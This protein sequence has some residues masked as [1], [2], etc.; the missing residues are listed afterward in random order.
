MVGYLYIFCLQ[1]VS[2]LIYFLYKVACWKIRCYDIDILSMFDREYCF[3][4]GIADGLFLFW[5]N[6]YRYHY[7][8]F[9]FGI[10][11][12]YSGYSLLYFCNWALRSQ[13][14]HCFLNFIPIATF[15]FSFVLR[16]SD[17]TDS[18]DRSIC[19]SAGL[20]LMKEDQSIDEQVNKKTLFSKT[21]IKLCK[22]ISVKSVNKYKE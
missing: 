6:T 18:D 20:M 2:L 22:N 11:L 16:R 13:V 5:Q 1:W 3:C 8:T 19:C 4:S 21:V 14:R 10:R 7:F 12:F 9:C 17:E 15:F